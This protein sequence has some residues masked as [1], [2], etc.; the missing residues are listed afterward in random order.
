MLLDGSYTMI[1]LISRLGIFVAL[2]GLIYAVVIALGRFLF[3]SQIPGW[4]PIITVLL[5]NTGLIMVMLGLIAEYQWRIYDHLRNKPLYIIEAL[6][7]GTSGQH[8]G[9]I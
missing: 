2:C 8:D 4:A 3:G 5:V 9:V 7:D 6:R 1:L